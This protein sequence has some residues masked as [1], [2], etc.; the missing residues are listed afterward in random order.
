MYPI[1]IVN[2]AWNESEL[3][4]PLVALTFGK[5]P[6]QLKGSGMGTE[7]TQTEQKTETAAPEQDR[8]LLLIGIFKLLKALF[9]CCVG[10]GA[11]HL[12]QKNL[13]EELMRLVVAF[14]RD[15]EGRLVQLM[16]EKAD[17]VDAHRL[18][19]IGFG[20]FAYSALALTE[21]VG[22][23]LQK[24]WAEY[25]TLILTVSFLPWELFELATRPSWIRVAVLLTNL[26]VLGYLIWLLQR[27]KQR[28]IHTTQSA[29]NVVN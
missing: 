14:R 5:R 16:L 12:I 13:G 27:K 24:V 3:L 18:R 7:V 19:Q 15:P 9:F 20:S 25:L 8:G 29:Q 26:A 4:Y 22:L 17:L 11:I 2:S 23:M 1:S 10:F 28:Q 21:G 6:R